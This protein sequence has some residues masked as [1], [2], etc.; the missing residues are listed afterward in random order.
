MNK[1]DYKKITQALSY[2]AGKNGGAINYMKAIKLVYLSDRLHLRKYG[3]L[4]TNDQMVGMKNG[5]VGSQTKDVATL[6]GDFLPYSAYQYAEDNLVKD[7]FII[8][9]QRKTMEDLSET[10]IECL[11]VIFDKLG[12]INEFDLANK[13]TH[14]LPEWKRHEYEI[15]TEG[16]TCVDIDELD[17]FKSPIS[18][19]VLKEIYNQ[20]ET[21]LALSRDLYLECKEREEVI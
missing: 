11:D 16:K 6:N 15:V 3:R 17:M 12:S 5:T 21:E 20:S 9:T 4:I 10:D 13:V 1:P 19:P 7:N 2:I 8:K 14:D 18:I